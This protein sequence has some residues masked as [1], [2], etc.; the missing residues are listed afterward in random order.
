MPNINW[1]SKIKNRVSI[2]KKFSQKSVKGDGNSSNA[3]KQIFQTTK[4]VATGNIMSL[5]SLYQY[6]TI[7]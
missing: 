5:Y 1:F 2:T 3:W 7:S 6:A 4:E